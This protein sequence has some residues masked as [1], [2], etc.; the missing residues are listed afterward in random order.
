MIAPPQ[1][2]RRLGGATVFEG[3]LATLLLAW[4]VGLGVA[5][6]RLNQWQQEVAH[7]LVQLRADDL[8]RASVVPGRDTIEPE[9]YRRRALALLA[10]VER[11]RDNT[12]WRLVM[13]GSWRRFDDLEERATAHI[14][15]A[16]GVVVVETVER[17]L[18]LRASQLT[19][20]PV[21][22]G[23]N[24]GG[25]AEA[26]RCA[27]PRADRAAPPRPA[28]ALADLP[29]HA[30]LARFLEQARG[31]D[32]AVSA[33]ASLQLG[34][35]AHP[36]DLRFL[37]RYAL[38]AEL[39]GSA[40]RSLALFH[41]SAPGSDAQVRALPARIEA[42]LRCSLFKGM[43]E[44]HRRWLMGNALLSTEEALL[45]AA[46]ARL[47]DRRDGEDFG[48]QHARMREVANL[49]EQQRRYLAQ[50]GQPWMRSGTPQLGPDHEQLLRQVQSI[51]LLG[52][53]A[54]DQLR[55]RA[56]ASHAQFRRRFDALF[57]R[58]GSG[59][60]WKGEGQGYALSEERRAL[61]E[62][63][64]AL[65]REPFMA[66]AQP[67]GLQ[68]ARQA[69]LHHGPPHELVALVQQRRSFL[70]GT[71]QRFAPAIRPA[72]TRFVDGR[73]ADLA[74]QQAT[75]YLLADLD[76][77]GAPWA[78]V[79]QLRERVGQ[80]Q[81]ALV[82]AGAPSM[83]ARLR[84]RLE[85]DLLAPLLQMEASLRVLPLFDARLADFS[86]WQG[87]GPPLPAL[88]GL[89]SASALQAFVGE[90]VQRLESAGAAAPDTGA[91]SSGEAMLQRW[92]PLREE[93]ARYRLGLPGS[94]LLALEDYLGR[95]LPSLRRDNCGELLAWQALPA[96]NDPVSQQLLRIHRALA[97][98]CQEVRATVL[99][100]V[101][102]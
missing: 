31:L 22:A 81:A 69:P 27:A 61:G 77:A 11:M 29:E 67:S 1:R 89:G 53:A 75:G 42:A 21:K 52:P 66:D 59:V 39:S 6:V 7:V 92:S 83:A 100:L 9:W 73:L 4:A 20:V 55:E 37:V 8:L 80:V 45:R 99:P 76:A 5:A 64:E 17:E 74:Y 3:L 44:L 12:T 85:R 26:T 10:A 71:L 30:A 41:A 49:I 56:A 46:P 18:D 23:M 14:A 28:A 62:G 96:G 15:R 40:S 87:E 25:L 84:S 78:G 16:F 102:G 38:G 90:Q 43:D 36:D 98:R 51:S 19:G 63:L 60:V 65:L 50:G 68:Q 93:V 13:P 91:M 94:S 54:A 32:Q 86:A 58:T 70:R 88:P 72:V 82:D 57:A 101:P 95:V 47:F 34:G 24:M 97:T 35:Q 79:A 33:L 2:R 48:V